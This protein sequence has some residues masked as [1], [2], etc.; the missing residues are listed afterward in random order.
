M[1]GIMVKVL[2]KADPLCLLDWSFKATTDTRL[3]HISSKYWNS[4]EPRTDIY[5]LAALL[6]GLLDC[7]AELVADGGLLCPAVVPLAPALQLVH[8]L[9]KSFPHVSLLWSVPSLPANHGS[10]GRQTY[11]SYI[12]F[13]P[14]PQSAATVLCYSYYSYHTKVQEAPVCALCFVCV[15]LGGFFA[16]M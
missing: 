13:S 8:C 5:L 9:P 4:S 15:T 14:S 12:T 1:S 11:C 16:C 2:T 6:R 7:N 3:L 10:C